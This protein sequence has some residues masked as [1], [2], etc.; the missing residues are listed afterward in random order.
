[1]LSASELAT[2]PAGIPVE[3]HCGA[4]DVVTPPAACEEAAGAL[5]ATFQLIANAGHASPVEQPAAV[6]A[7]LAAALQQQRTGENQDD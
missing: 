5:G 2:V 1:M 6:A 4:A 7:L 3:V